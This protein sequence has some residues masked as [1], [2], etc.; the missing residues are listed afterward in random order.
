[1]LIVFCI[2][3]YSVTSILVLSSIV[4]DLEPLATSNDFSYAYTFVFVFS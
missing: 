3:L 1:M 4:S 2:S